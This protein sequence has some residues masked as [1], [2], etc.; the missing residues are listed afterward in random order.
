MDL[1]DRAADSRFSMR[2]QKS[3]IKIAASAPAQA[4]ESTGTAH[5]ADITSNPNGV[6]V[7]AMSK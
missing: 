2:A 6:Y 1:G 7:P 4:T 5:S 3:F